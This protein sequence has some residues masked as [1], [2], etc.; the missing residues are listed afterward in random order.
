MPVLFPEISADLGLSIVAIGT[1]WGMDPLAGVLIGLP[2]GLLVDRLGVKRVLTVVCI[3]AGIFCALR[4]FSVDF[5]SMAAFMFLFGLMAAVTPSI[6]PKVTAIWFAGKRLGLANGLLNVSWSMGT[7]IATLSSAT[8]LSPWLGGWQN[9]LFFFGIPPVLL[10]FLWLFTGREPQPVNAATPASGLPI[11]KSLARVM[12][13]RDVWL[14]ALILL[15]YWGSNMG[16]SG[17][18]PLYIEDVLGWEKTTAATAM[19]IT[20]GIGIIGVLPLVLFSDRIGSRKIALFL[21]TLVVS[22]SIGLIPLVGNTGFWVLLVLGGLLRTGVTAIINTTVFEIKG[23]GATYAGTAIGITNTLGM[24]GATIAPP[25]G[26]S[27][28]GISSSLPLYFWGTLSLLAL[29]LIIMVK[30]TGT[31]AQIVPAP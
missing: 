17:Y 12:H 19:T 10:G 2:G 13:L 20:S 26:N 5:L 24:L 18:L 6:V 16:F 29:P 11:K 22:L 4:G 14:M 23:V 28:E 3:L 25:I 1:I 8:L 30:E 15:T 7:V 27:L 21:S 31:R 9:V